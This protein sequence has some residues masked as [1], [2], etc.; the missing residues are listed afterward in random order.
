MKSLTISN[1]KALFMD[2]S[3]IELNIIFFNNVSVTLGI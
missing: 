3:F 2:A 1:S